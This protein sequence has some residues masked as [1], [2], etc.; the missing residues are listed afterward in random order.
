MAA[1]DSKTVA[2]IMADS[3]ADAVVSAA[4]SA[5][6]IITTVDTAVKLTTNAGASKPDTLPAT[7][8]YYF[9]FDLLPEWQSLLTT[10]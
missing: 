4:R 6:G 10:E 3:V 8:Y 5:S 9:R 1:R 2:V 7:S